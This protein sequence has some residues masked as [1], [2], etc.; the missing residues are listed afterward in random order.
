M[1]EILELIAGI[2]I[3]GELSVTMT[4]ALIILVLINSVIGFITVIVLL[5]K[6]I[7]GRGKG[8]EDQYK[9]WIKTG[10]V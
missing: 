9:K 1:E 2:A 4:K 10:K 7:F 3:I 6:L 5:C 8:K